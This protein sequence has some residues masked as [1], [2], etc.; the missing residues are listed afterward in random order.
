[1]DDQIPSD[2]L[3][4]TM[5]HTHVNCLLHVVFSTKGR[6][7]LIAAAWRTALHAML[8]NIAK[9]RGFPTVIVGGVSDHVH[10]LMSLP[11]D[12]P[13]SGCLRT[14]KSTSSKW[15][16]DEYVKDRSFA[17]QDGYGA[18]AISPSHKEAT[19]AYIEGQEEHHRERTFQ[20]EY[21][22]FLQR[23]GVTWDERY[24]WG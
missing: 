1:M 10:L 3:A 12:Q 14:L 8:S 13:I 17:W 15:V 11:S 23:N 16:N 24:V 7:P 18:F 22:E 20:E 6:A 9:N 19:V 2:I 21:R 4:T 5:A